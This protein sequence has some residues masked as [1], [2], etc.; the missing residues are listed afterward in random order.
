MYY[1]IGVFQK[2]LSLKGYTNDIMNGIKMPPP[3]GSGENERWLRTGGFSIPGLSDEDRK[4]Q[5]GSHVWGKFL[6]F[7]GGCTWSFYLFLPLQYFSC[8]LTPNVKNI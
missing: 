5:F 2:K 3:P 8:D 4:L 6:Y 7:L 1:K